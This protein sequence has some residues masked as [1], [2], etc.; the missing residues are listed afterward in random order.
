MP[1]RSYGP[2]AARD[3]RLR[4][5]PCRSARS[6]SRSTTSTSTSARRASR[7]AIARSCGTPKF[8]PPAKRPPAKRGARADD[9]PFT[10]SLAEQR[11]GGT[12][13]V[14]VSARAS[15]R[16]PSGAKNRRLPFR[17]ERPP[18]HRGSVRPR[19]RPLERPR[20][21]GRSAIRG[22][23]AADCCESA[24]AGAATEA[25]GGRVLEPRRDPGERRGDELRAARQHGFPRGVVAHGSAPRRSSEPPGAILR[26]AAVAP[27]RVRAHRR[28]ARCRA[29]RRPAGSTHPAAAVRRHV[30]VKH[31]AGPR[32]VIGGGDRHGSGLVADSFPHA[33]PIPASAAA[34]NLARRARI[35]LLASSLTRSP[36]G[37]ALRLFVAL[38]LE[39]RGER[40]VDVLPHERI[41]ELRAWP[42]THSAAAP[43]PPPHVLAWTQPSQNSGSVCLYSLTSRAGDDRRG[44]D[45]VVEDVRAPPRPVPWSVQLRRRPSGPSANSCI[46]VPIAQVPNSSGA[47]SS[48]STAHGGTGIVHVRRIRGSAV[49]SRTGSPGETRRGDR[50]A[51]ARAPRRGARRSPAGLK[52]ESAMWR[53]PSDRKSVEDLARRARAFF[54][55]TTMQPT[56]GTPCAHERADAARSSSRSARRRRHARR[57]APR[58]GRRA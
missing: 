49:A 36:R 32:L 42:S 58:R 6:A 22:T 43:Q 53:T 3:D 11:P 17:T 50:R 18:R 34:T 45:V 27:F 12:P 38:A 30:A 54:L 4:D 29:P 35:A 15:A 46:V 41:G 52:R 23:G 57:G 5:R 13:A 9:R 33:T 56:T 39:P 21:R 20:P 16:R 55:V 44:I 37:D 14:W 2:A 1:T 8:A 51:T 24:S 25:G 19:P 7:A 26:H 10:R 48:T 31:G 40:V 28:Q 47:S